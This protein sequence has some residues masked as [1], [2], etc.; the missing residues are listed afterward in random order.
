[1]ENPR[2][3]L[4][5]FIGRPYYEFDPTEFGDKHNKRTQLWG[6]FNKPVKTHPFTKTISHAIS[7]SDFEPLPADYIPDPNMRWDAI[8]RSITPHG[9]ANAFY[10]ANK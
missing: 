1:M 9:F 10:K 8:R 3:Y 7:N 4:Q 6:Y 2:G 5:Q